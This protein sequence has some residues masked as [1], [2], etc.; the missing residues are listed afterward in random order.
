[1]NTDAFHTSGTSPTQKRDRKPAKRLFNGVVGSLLNDV[2]LA[3]PPLLSAPEPPAPVKRGRPPKYGVAMTPAEQKRRKREEKAR[4]DVLADLNRRFRRMQQRPF[5]EGKNAQIAMAKAAAHLSYQRKMFYL[6]IRYLPVHELKTLRDVWAE[7]ADRR[8]AYNNGMREVNVGT[9]IDI[10]ADAQRRDEDRGFRRVK[11]SGNDPAFLERDFPQQFVS[12]DALVRGNNF[13]QQF[14]LGDAEGGVNNEQPV[15]SGDKPADEKTEKRMMRVDLAARWL[16]RSGVCSVCGIKCDDEHIWAEYW[17]GVQAQTRQDY[18]NE[19][20]EDLRA[21]LHE[22][23]PDV[24][25]HISYEDLPTLPGLLPFDQEHWTEIQKLLRKKL[26]FFGGGSGDTPEGE[27][28]TPDELRAKG[29]AVFWLIKDRREVFLPSQAAVRAFF[30][31]G[32][33]VSNWHF[34]ENVGR[35]EE[36]RAWREKR[37]L[38]ELSDTAPN[39]KCGP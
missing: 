19:V 24:A 4:R 36:W 35:E 15:N 13:R 18:Y 11:P 7:T 27:K 39:G 20:A 25:Q 31:D 6:S 38:A 5:A 8:G 34:I 23:D 1:M 2:S 17:K 30:E 37:R 22:I 10:V 21:R 29:W 9:K 14:H 16:T 12:G 3:E 28:W 26:K 33:I 32:C